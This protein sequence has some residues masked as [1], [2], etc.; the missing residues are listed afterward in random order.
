V[1]SYQTLDLRQVPTIVYTVDI[2][3][4][5]VPHS[6]R[7]QRVTEALSGLGVA[8]VT[9]FW[10]R[11]CSPYWHN[12]GPDHAALLRNHPP[13][14]LI[15]EDD[16]LPHV[17]QPWIAYP[18]PADLLYLGGG[19][20]G[21]PAGARRARAAGI[22]CAFGRYWGWQHI[23]RDYLRVFGML[24][25]H[26]ILYLSRTAQLEVAEV[27]DQT[28]VTLD[29]ALAL[30]QYRWH[31]LCKRTPMWY[32]DDGHHSGITRNFAPSYR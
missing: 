19:I 10:G 31:C 3:E 1:Q 7:R 20:Y 13:P 4:C 29:A 2:E 6:L 24:Y 30:E 8:S 25:T 23:D 18:E 27:I 16:V 15:L 32:Q 9:F 17:L 21:W 22:R 5:P 26:A 11:R 28:D 12:V 14:L